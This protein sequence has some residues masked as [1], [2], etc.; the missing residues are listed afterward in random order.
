M[1]FRQRCIRLDAAD[2][3]AS[4]TSERAFVNASRKRTSTR[5][6]ASTP[7]TRSTACSSTPTPRPARLRLLHRPVPSL[8]RRHRPGGGRAQ[9]PRLLGHQ[10]RRQ[11]PDRP[12]TWRRNWAGIVPNT[13]DSELLPPVPRGRRSSATWWRRTT[14]ATP[15][16]CR[17]RGAFGNGIL[18][19]G[20]NDSGRAQPASTTPT[21]ASSSPPI[22][23]STSG[24][25]RA[26][27]WA[28]WS[29]GR[30][31][32]LALAAPAAATA[33]RPTRPGPRSRWGCRPSSAAGPAPAAA[34][35][36]VHHPGQPWPGRRG[37]HRR[38]P[39]QPPEDQPAPPHQEQLPGGARGRRCARP[40][41]CSPPTGSTWPR[42]PPRPSDRPATV[43]GANRVRRP[44]PRHIPLAAR[45]RPYGYLLP[46]VLYAAWTPGP[47]G[48]GPPTTC[49]G[50]AIGWIA[51][52][53]L[54]PFLG[55]IAYHVLGRPCAGRRAGGG[56]RRPGRLPG[57]ARHRRPPGR[58]RRQE[59][60]GAGS[61]RVRP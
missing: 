17:C 48:P 19:G 53:L 3:G 25:R 1:C 29:R 46:F 26:T 5:T 54:V 18:L 55:V 49:R 6:T 50:A 45:L 7:S 37:Q 23:T 41:A 43:R 52:V 57:R 61:V 11:P 24:P 44:D 32:D 21:T 20:G 40:S 4:S 16:G 9:R 28:T 42:S 39:G 22:W 58:D 51:V 47:V 12:P 59:G 35:G 13:L 27:G 30:P 31:A 38:L 33:S 15:R 34:H 8:R 14:T 2:T 36:P 10:R 56:R 60:T